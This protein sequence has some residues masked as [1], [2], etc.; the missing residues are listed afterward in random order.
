MRSPLD[1]WS[2]QLP[3][4]GTIKKTFVLIVTITLWPEMSSMAKTPQ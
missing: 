1:Q 2:G 4:K 3:V